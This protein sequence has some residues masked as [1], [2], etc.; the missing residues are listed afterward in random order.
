[1][2]DKDDAAAVERAARR[3]FELQNP[4]KPWP[5]D[6]G[7]SRAGSDRSVAE[8]PAETKKG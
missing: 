1:M 8:K 5:G 4:G 2:A 6:A 3:I 7:A